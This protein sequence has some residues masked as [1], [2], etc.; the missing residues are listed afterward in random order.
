MNKSLLKLIE[1]VA[2]EFGYDPASIKAFVHVETGGQGF[3]PETGKII[4]Q[5]EPSW[6]R[7]N[8]PYAPS[9]KWSLNKVDRQ[10]QEWIAFNDAFAKNADAALKSTSIGVGQIM[11]FH[12]SRLGYK[13]VG[14]M[15]DDAKR[16]ID[17][18]LWQLCKFIQTDP[19]LELAI[20]KRKWT[21]VAVLYNGPKFREIAKKYNRVPY[22]AAMAN[23][24]N[25]YKPQL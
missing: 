24:Y 11:G 3:D 9:G 12:Y 2:V 19:L 5:F 8:A 21:S 1:Q 20:R 7:K 15:W 10:R 18:Q 17:R 16:G 23:A 4:I 25:L 14:D 6:F 13:T 22:D